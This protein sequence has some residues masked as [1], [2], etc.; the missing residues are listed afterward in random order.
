MGQVMGVEA[1]QSRMEAASLVGRA[2]R[3]GHESEE[4]ATLAATDDGQ[5][6]E[7]SALAACSPDKGCPALVDGSGCGDDDED[8][9]DGDRSPFDDVDLRDSS[10]E[11][12]EAHVRALRSSFDGPRF[13]SS[14][15]AS[16]S[17]LASPVL[18]RKKPRIVLVPTHSSSSLQD[19]GR[20]SAV[21]G[22]EQTAWRQ[23]ALWTSLTV[24][25][26][27]TMVVGAA[28]ALAITTARSNR[29]SLALMRA[30]RHW[31]AAED[32]GTQSPLEHGRIPPP[33]GTGVPTLFTDT[34]NDTR[35]FGLVFR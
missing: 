2:Q 26:I 20:S 12:V 21:R 7:T 34:A 24:T 15:E 3:G 10:P 35:Q 25:A 22:L 30:L 16:R 29:R 19:S 31:Y 33:A 17:P 13:C 11:D 1:E 9:D 27:V 4:A 28:V 32:N 8:Y 23:Q 18:S 6:A 14:W 5:T